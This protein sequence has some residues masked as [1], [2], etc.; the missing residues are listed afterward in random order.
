[1][2]VFHASSCVLSVFPPYYEVT[3]ESK[4]V[5]LDDI[6]GYYRKT[7]QSNEVH[8]YPRQ[9]IFKK[10]S[11]DMFLLQEPDTGD[12]IFAE[13][14]QG[15]IVRARQALA[16]YQRYPDNTMTKWKLA[17]G[18]W[19]TDI[20]VTARQKAPNVNENETKGGTPLLRTMIPKSEKDP[21]E[22]F[23]VWIYFSC[24]Y[25][26][27]MLSVAIIIVIVFDFKEEEEY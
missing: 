21:S 9:P 17:N 25:G 27:G 3:G 15:Q 20:N 11:A 6:V 18:F 7:S 1:M 2:P 14:F 22:I 5:E 26:A 23:Y 10:V 24:G 19:K 8:H 12:W 13:D 16:N 4:Y